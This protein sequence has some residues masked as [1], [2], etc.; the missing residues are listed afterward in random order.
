MIFEI[1]NIELNFKNSCILKG[2]YLRAEPGKITGIL[3]RNGCGKTSLLKIIFGNLKPKYK[4]V[5]I[6]NKPILKP[7]Y[8]TN[9]VG[10]LAQNHFIPNTLT[11]KTV[12]RLFNIS[13]ELFKKNFKHLSISKNS[14]L[15]ALSGGEKRIIETYVIIMSDKKIILLD[16]PFSH[17]A[18]VYIEKIKSL[19][20]EARKEKI[21]IITDHLYDH[22]TEVS[23]N[24]YFIKDGCSKLLTTKEELKDYKYLNIETLF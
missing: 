9:I 11:I 22:I 14:R 6:D 17:I 23:D 19:I 7:L 10:L 18:P 4:L 13:W 2:I 5:R 24:L 12:F 21:I 20:I 3:G 8:Q 1:D 15:N 16:E